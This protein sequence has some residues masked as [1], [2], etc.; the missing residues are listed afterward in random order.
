MSLHNSCCHV[1]EITQYYCRAMSLPI[2]TSVHVVC[3]GKLDDESLWVIINDFYDTTVDWSLDDA[4][5]E[6]FLSLVQRLDAIGASATEDAIDWA[7]AHG[8]LN[9][10]QWLTRHRCDGATVI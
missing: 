10:V 9:I 6:G 3:R 8:H 4:A 2:L 5:R 7:A 1:I